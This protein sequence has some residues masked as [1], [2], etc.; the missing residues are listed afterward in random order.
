[1]YIVLLSLILF[2]CSN[3]KEEKSENNLNNANIPGISAS[4]NNPDSL[5]KYLHA[6]LS[7]PS[8]FTY[9]GKFDED[10]VTHEYA[11]GTEISTKKESGIKFSLLKP[12]KDKLIISYQSRLLKG[13]FTKSAQRIVRPKGFTYD[14]I[15]YSSLNYFMGAKFGEIFTYLIDFKNKEIYYSHLFTTDGN[16]FSIFLSENIKDK[17]I[18][19]YLLTPFQKDF[20]S[21]LIVKKDVD[22]DNL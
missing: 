22:L 11:A 1:M 9:P 12:D 13:S 10:S 16:S 4:L 18:K 20:S 7:A 2:A 6:A 15:Y 5:K 14:M 17:S 21:A 3:K 8:M 19:D